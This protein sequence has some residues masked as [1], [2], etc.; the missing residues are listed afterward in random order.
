[1]WGGEGRPGLC[2]GPARGEAPLDRH[3][4][5]CRGRDPRQPGRE[6]DRRSRGPCPLAGLGRAQ[7]CLPKPAAPVP[8]TNRPGVELSRHVGTAPPWRRAGPG[9]VRR[10]GQGRARPHQHRQDPPRHRAAARALLGHHR[11][12]AA[13]AGA[14]ELRP[15]GGGQGGAARRA[16]HRG[17]EDRAA[18]GALVLLHHRGDAAG[19][20]R[21]VP[22]GG[23]DPAVRRPR[24]RARVH[25]PAAACARA[26]GDHVPGGGDHTPAAAAPGAAG[27]GADAAAAVAAEPRGAGQ[28]DQAAAALGGGRVQRGGGL[29]HRRADPPASRRVRGGDGAAQPAHAQCAGGAVPGEGGGLPGR[30]RRDRHGAEHGRGPCGVRAAV[31][32]RR[33][34][35][36]GR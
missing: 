9:A 28:A 35:A 11:L 20:P 16:D 2:P 23:R 29:R 36:R 15:H 30:D 26:G 17:G 13:A 8:C 33:A 14:G 19:P 5:P 18:R 10:P 31:Q 12:S 32:V 34:S 4:F 27:G 7:P 3:D 21:R 24:S 25:R 1:M 22:G 6:A